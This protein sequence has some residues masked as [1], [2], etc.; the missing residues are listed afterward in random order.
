MEVDL[1]YKETIRAVKDTFRAENGLLLIENDRMLLTDRDF[2]MRSLL[3]NEQSAAH[4]G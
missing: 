1:H 3:R 4:S 2:S